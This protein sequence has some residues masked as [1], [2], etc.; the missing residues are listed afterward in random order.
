MN[1]EAETLRTKLGELATALQAEQQKLSQVVSDYQRQF[2]EAQEKRSQEYTEALRQAQED[3][4]KVTTDQQGQFSTAQDARSREFADNQTT[5]QGRFDDIIADYTN[6]LAQ[7]NADFT[8]QRDGLIR[9]FEITLGVLNS[10]YVEKAG[11]I[12]EA[13]HERQARVEKLVGVI[14][15]LS[16]TS[17]YLTTANHA[18]RAILP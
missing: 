1:A 9:D 12:L 14:G 13:L 16:L 18:R 11:V 10:E 6:R 4:A 5:R 3:F 15:N 17:G 8:T 7:Q 2:S